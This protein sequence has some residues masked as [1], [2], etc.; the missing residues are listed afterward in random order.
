MNRFSSATSRRSSFTLFPPFSSRV[1]ICSS[2]CDY[3]L[4]AF[5]CQRL[6]TTTTQWQVH[7]LRNREQRSSKARRVVECG[8]RESRT[9]IYKH[10]C[11]LKS[12]GLLQFIECNFYFI[13][14]LMHPEAFEWQTD[15]LFRNVENSVNI[16]VEERRMQSGI[17]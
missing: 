15:D 12:G 14:L 7:M 8:K 5:L 9:R 4:F 1:R 3:I 10:G 2:L 6:M 11:R 13:A 16:E 17:L